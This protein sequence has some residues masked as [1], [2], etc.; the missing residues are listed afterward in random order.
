[1]KTFDFLEEI[2]A[3]TWCVP[4]IG[5]FENNQYIKWDKNFFNRYSYKISTAEGYTCVTTRI[6]DF[7]IVD[8]NNDFPWNWEIISTK[9]DWI[10]DIGFVKRH[11]TQLNL[12]KS[13]ELL[14]SELSVLYLKA[15]KYRRFY[16]YIPSTKL[17]LQTLQLSN[18]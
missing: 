4:I 14:S 9:A 10:K 13:F 11:L 7:T 12:K 2:G 8:D 16:L 18:L 17:K 5:G 15:Q 3:L 6:S 1:M